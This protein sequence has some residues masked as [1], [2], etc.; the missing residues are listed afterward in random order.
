[1][2]HPDTIC[3]ELT[4]GCPLR[5]VHC[6]ASAS[7]FGVDRLPIGVLVQKL[8]QLP[9]LREIYLSG[10]EPFT[11]PDF[12]ALLDRSFSLAETVVV[13]S[14]GVDHTPVGT[15][16]LSFAE[17]VRAHAAGLSRIDLSLY[18]ASAESHEVVTKTPGSFEATLETARRAWL[19]NIAVGVHF[20]PIGKAAAEVRDVFAIAE[21]IHAS[22]FHV[23]ALVPQ[24]RG[25]LRARDHVPSEKFWHD[26]AALHSTTRCEVVLSSA[27]RRAIGQSNVTPRDRMLA[28][29]VDCQG[30]VYPAEG[31]RSPDRR[32]RRTIFE[33]ADPSELFAAALSS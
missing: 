28:A 5:C 22:R 3:I 32:S 9:R 12:H 26:V 25:A 16:P 6:S 14:S 11:H 19:T 23:L 20:V 15:T 29:H 4:N 24:G 13:Y 31:S 27:I 7:P 33:V 8:Q 2:R 18:G 17:L 21:S 30:Y 10:G 1:M